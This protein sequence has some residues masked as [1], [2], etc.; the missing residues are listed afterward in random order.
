[1]RAHR[2]RRP[3]RAAFPGSS[4]GR[5][6]PPG[7]W[8]GPCAPSARGDW[9]RPRRRDDASVA[10]VVKMDSGQP[11]GD[12]CRGPRSAPK[13]AVSEQLSVRGGEQE[14][15]GADGRVG[16]EMLLN[17]SD[18]RAGQGGAC[19]PR[20]SADILILARTATRPQ[21]TRHADRQARRRAR[22]L[23]QRPHPHSSHLVAKPGMK[24]PGGLG[25][26]SQT[27]WRRSARPPSR[28]VSTTDRLRSPHSWCAWAISAAD[29]TGPSSS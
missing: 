29:A 13:N 26:W 15:V 24:C 17:L 20:S 7:C 6:V 10:Q 23:R 25:R 27:G 22:P 14:R 18:N 1:V 5:S 19:Q 2:W 21:L 9:P 8:R 28:T 16:V 11:C 12:E 3:G 4:G